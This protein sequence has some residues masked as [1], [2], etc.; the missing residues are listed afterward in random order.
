MENIFGDSITFFKKIK[1]ALL[2]YRTSASRTHEF[3]CNS[4]VYE[5]L[6]Y[7]LWLNYI[8]KLLEVTNKHIRHINIFVLALH[9]SLLNW[10]H[11][12]KLRELV[13][14]NVAD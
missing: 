7:L 4:Y 6:N 3:L 9:V 10:Q 8:Y 12:Q 5:T 13:F 2:V 11:S 1:F 14:D